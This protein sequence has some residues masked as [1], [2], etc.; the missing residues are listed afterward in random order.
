MKSNVVLL[1][2]FINCLCSFYKDELK[3][4]ITVQNVQNLLAQLR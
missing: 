4:Q 1:F 3:E 2:L